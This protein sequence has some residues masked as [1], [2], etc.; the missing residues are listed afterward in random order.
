MENLEFVLHVYR[1][2]SG[3]MSGQLWHGEHIVC[4]V[5]GCT[6]VQEVEEAVDDQG[7]VVDRVVDA[8]SGEAL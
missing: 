1:S 4:G 5:A 2:L 3:Q 8:Q 7:F 6:S